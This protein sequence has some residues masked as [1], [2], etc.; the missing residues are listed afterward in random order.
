MDWYSCQIAVG[1]QIVF[2]GLIW[3]DIVWCVFCNSYVDKMWVYGMLMVMKYSEWKS[4][5]YTESAL[6]YRTNLSVYSLGHL[7]KWV[8]Q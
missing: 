3:R 4:E 5:D 2:R 7:I 6:I 1:S 8:I